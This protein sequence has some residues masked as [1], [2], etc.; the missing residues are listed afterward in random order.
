MKTRIF[1]D[2]NSSLFKDAKAVTYAFYPARISEIKY[3]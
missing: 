2:F 1:L 3:S